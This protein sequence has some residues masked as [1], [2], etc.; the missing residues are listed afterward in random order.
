MHNLYHKILYD[1]YV[2][3]SGIKPPPLP[4]YYPKNIFKE[5]IEAEKEGYNTKT[6]KIKDWYNLLINK[7]VTHQKSQ[8]DYL[9]ILTRLEIF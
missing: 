5:I 3:N 1:Y 2:H 6:M 9:L 7:Y 8:D 4:P